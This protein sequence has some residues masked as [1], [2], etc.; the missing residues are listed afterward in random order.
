MNTLRLAA[1]ALISATVLPLPAA[2]APSAPPPVAANVPAAPTGAEVRALGLPATI[3]SDAVVTKLAG[4]FGFTEGATTAPN[5][6]VYFV[7]QNNNKILKWDVTVGKLS[8][9]LEPAGRANGQ[10][11]DGK[12]NLISCADERNELWSIT[13]DGKHTVLISALGYQGKPL[14]G[15][16]DV[17]VRPDGGIYVTDPM[18]ARTWWDPAVTRPSQAVRSVYYLDPGHKTLTR[19]A[20]FTMPNGI[21]GTPDGKTLYVSDI[22]ARQI[23][24]FDIQPEGALTN[25]RLIGNFGSDG[26]TLDDR[27]NL[28]LSANLGGGRGG[29]GARGGAPAPAAADG[30]A[31]GPAPVPAPAAAAPAAPAGPTTG[32]TVVDT[33]TGQAIGFIPVPEQ[34]ANLAFGGKDRS[35]LYITARTGFYSIPTKVKG[36]NPAK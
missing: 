8:T 21:V 28:Y 11:F 25:K 18:Y 2:D 30:A 32:V 16:N 3:A 35:T 4:D 27:G 29:R 5:G 36:A 14:D 24:A 7:D 10:Y 33:K 31:P 12:G 26:M 34:P 9:F 6:D 19:V 22:N 15:P 20:D 23:L 1:F 13:P 17:W